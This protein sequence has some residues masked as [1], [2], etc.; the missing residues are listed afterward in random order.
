VNDKR[1]LS[2]LGKSLNIDCCDVVLE[3]SQDLKDLLSEKDL[4]FVEQYLI[5]KGAR[6]I[7]E[8]TINEDENMNSLKVC[9]R[10]VS[11]AKNREEVYNLV[12]SMVRDNPFKP[13]FKTGYK[14]IASYLNKNGYRDSRGFKWKLKVLIDFYH[15]CKRNP[16]VTPTKSKS[17]PPKSVPPKSVVV[18]AKSKI[19]ATNPT[20]KLQDLVKHI[21]DSNLDNDLKLKLIPIV[22][23]G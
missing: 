13:G 7:V 16:P 18:V 2:E 9:K 5:Q 15:N 8:E 6:Y 22:L 12:H 14:E 17:V 20:H 1:T 11:G 4:N 3:S 23:K 19:F 10:G 21:I